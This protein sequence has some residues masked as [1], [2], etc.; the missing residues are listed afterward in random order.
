[1]P[2]QRLIRIANGQG[3]WGDSP[4]APLDQVRRG[5]IDYLT[6]DYSGVGFFRRELGNACRR[7]AVELGRLGGRAPD[8]N[9][10]LIGGKNVVGHIDGEHVG[11]CP[12]VGADLPSPSLRPPMARES[13]LNRA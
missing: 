13:S 11:G 7:R 9:P 10:R 3:F 12:V 5:P 2:D 4:D 8:R 1:M 6:L